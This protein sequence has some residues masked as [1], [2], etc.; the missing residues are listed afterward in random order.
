MYYVDDPVSGFF[1]QGDIFRD[2]YITPS[3]SAPLIVRS[4]TNTKEIHQGGALLSTQ[5]NTEDFF[6]DDF[7]TI[8]IKAI[9]TNI[10]IVSQ[11]C[12]IQNREFVIIAPI[13]SLSRIESVTK[14]RAIKEGKTFYRFYFPAKEGVIEESYADLTLLNSIKKDLLPPNKQLLSL[15][16]FYRNHF[17]YNLNRFFCRPFMP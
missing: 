5:E 10:I 3:S 7:E 9:R 8:A 16:D 11:T 17:T 14:A 1:F 2:L 15:T 4:V 6:S 12:D 13:F